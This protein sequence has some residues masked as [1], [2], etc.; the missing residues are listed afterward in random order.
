[1]SI[2][3]QNTVVIDND[4]NIINSP[5]ATFTGTGFVKLPGGD[6]GQRPTPAASVEG[7]IRYNS[8]YND[9]EMFTEGSWYSLA[10]GGDT[11]D[12][13][14]PGNG[15]YANYANDFIITN[16]DFRKR[17]RVSTTSGSISISGDII[18]WTP[19]S[20]GTQAF[21]LNGRAFTATVVVSTFAP[22]DTILPFFGNTS[23]DLPPDGSWQFYS[24]TE[25]YIIGAGST[26]AVLA[27]STTS[28]R[29]FSASPTTNTQGNHSGTTS[30]YAPPTTW[31]NAGVTAQ[32]SHS[33]TFGANLTPEPLSRSYALIRCVRESPVPRNAGLM[34]ISSLTGL[35]EVSVPATRALFR[36]VS[37]SY[38]G[39]PV[40][41]GSNTRTRAYTAT[42][43]TGAHNHGATAGGASSG[44]GS[45]TDGGAPG[46]HLHTAAALT[47][48]AD[49]TAYRILSAWTRTDQRFGPPAGSIAMTLSA[50][51]PAG[52]VLCDGLNGTPDMR[53]RYL[54][55]GTSA[56][57][58]TA[59][60]TNSYTYPAP[61]GISTGGGH[62]HSWG[63]ANRGG[64]TSGYHYETQGA[65]SHTI[66]N[67]T[68]FTLTERL[69]YLALN[70]IRKT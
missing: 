22:V 15:I 19:T 18:T 10:G 61:S 52:W 45:G 56:Q 67:G 14:Y 32:G 49:N 41:A 4:R 65:H 54:C 30:T 68:S 28:T 63:I 29:T 7:M 12:E 50:T 51:A 46:S 1:V 36:T 47:A 60:G 37:G 6:S 17:Y 58:N 55:I 5:R 11:V 69:R 40:E 43:S 35:N 57:H 25:R 20:G 21:T 64:T 62:V 44:A 33:H 8:F 23:T 59:G 16:W 26:F 53:D 24:V 39:T 13:R 2:K 48:V 66:A 42:N 27:G 34:G 31:A 70:F 9:L 38:N 3:I